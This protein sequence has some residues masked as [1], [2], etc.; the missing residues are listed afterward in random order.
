MPPAYDYLSLVTATWVYSSVIAVLLLCSV[1]VWIA[2]LMAEELE[3][4]TRHETAAVGRESLNDWLRQFHLFNL[5]VEGINECFSPI[6]GIT[7]LCYGFYLSNFV[8]LALIKIVLIDKVS[9][10]P[11]RVNS[12]ISNFTV[13]GILQ[14][15]RF[16]VLVMQC[17][18]LQETVLRCSE[19]RVTMN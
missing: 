10:Y 8:Y 5:L 11:K 3:R 12:F 7:V 4:R 17:H 15:L 16:I 14:S 6:L 13:L 1:L 19:K 9:F 2:S 18:K